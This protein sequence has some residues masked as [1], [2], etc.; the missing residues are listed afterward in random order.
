MNPNFLDLIW[1]FEFLEAMAMQFGI[2]LSSI[3]ILFGAAVQSDAPSIVF[4]QE[5]GQH[6]G[7]KLLISFQTSQIRKF[8][9]HL[10]LSFFLSRLFDLEVRPEF[11]SGDVI[12]KVRVLP[13]LLEPSFQFS[14]SEMEGLTKWDP[15]RLKTSDE[16]CQIYSNI[17]H[18]D[19]QVSAVSMVAALEA[20]LEQAQAPIQEL[21]T[22]HRS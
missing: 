12:E 5:D 6:G 4:E 19:Q 15:V 11:A 22:D 14:N 13:R 18:I 2:S 8:V 9:N 7:N 16:A 17:K 20:D 10:G 3:L 1:V 21:E